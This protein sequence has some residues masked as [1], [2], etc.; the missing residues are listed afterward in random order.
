MCLTFHYHLFASCSL[1]LVNFFHPPVRKDNC[2]LTSL[3]HLRSDGEIDLC[4]TAMVL[5]RQT[6]KE[7]TG[8]VGF[9]LSCAL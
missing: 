1:V 6:L 3:L 2:S 4:H 8:E 5:Q 7:Q 9:P